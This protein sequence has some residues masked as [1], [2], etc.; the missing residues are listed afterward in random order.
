MESR[1]T[2][3]YSEKINAKHQQQKKK[4]K[5]KRF[6]WLRTTKIIFLLYNTVGSSRSR[7]P[8]R[9]PSSTHYDSAKKEFI[10]NKRIVSQRSGEARNEKASAKWHIS[11][12][13]CL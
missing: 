9:A 8:D 10:K 2:G 6:N 1:K 4:T 3:K 7:H 11:A 13:R 5:A 12:A